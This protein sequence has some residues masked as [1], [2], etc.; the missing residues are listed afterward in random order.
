MGE[1]EEAEELNKICRKDD[2]EQLT[3]WQFNYHGK[4]D[5]ED[6]DD[7]DGTEGRTP[8]FD[9]PTIQCRCVHRVVLSLFQRSHPSRRQRFFFLQGNDFPA[10]ITMRRLRPFR[11]PQQYSS[12]FVVVVVVE[13]EV[14]AGPALLIFYF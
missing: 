7:G 2:G 6:D 3:D 5:G 14:F 8:H 12:L 1:E 13:L 9:T 10:P 4:E 11:T